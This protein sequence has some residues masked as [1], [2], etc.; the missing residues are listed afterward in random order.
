[1][2]LYSVTIKRSA[3]KSLKALPKGARQKLRVAIFGL[4]DEPRP[5]GH[6]T[7]D[8]KKKV[9]RIRV[10][11]YRAVYQVHD[12]KLLVLVVTIANRKD[13]YSRLQDLLKGLDAPE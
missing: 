11:S 8:S 12:G 13:V 3:A 2:S 4:A 1:M 5:H 6:K 9:Y 7:L 10:G